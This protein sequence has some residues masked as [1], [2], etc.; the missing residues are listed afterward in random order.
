MNKYV[1]K[2]RMFDSDGQPLVVEGSEIQYFCNVTEDGSGLKFAVD[3][4]KAMVFPGIPEAQEICSLIYDG[5]DSAY[6]H[7]VIVPKLSIVVK[8]DE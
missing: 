2:A 7:L 8:S 6:I 3:V 4:N 5:V 1:I